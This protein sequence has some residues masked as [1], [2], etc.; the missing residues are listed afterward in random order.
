MDRMPLALALV[1]RARRCRKNKIKIIFYSVQVFHN[2]HNVSHFFYATSAHTP[3]CKCLDVK[4]SQCCIIYVLLQTQPPWGE[5]YV[6]PRALEGILQDMHSFM[7]LRVHEEQIFIS[8]HDGQAYCLAGWP[9]SFNVSFESYIYVRSS[10]SVHL[11]TT[12]YSWSP[13]LV[14]SSIIYLFTSALYH[15]YLLIV[16]VSLPVHNPGYIGECELTSFGVLNLI[17][18]DAYGAKL[19]LTGSCFFPM[20]GHRSCR[21]WNKHGRDVEWN[22]WWQYLN[23]NEN[24]VGFGEMLNVLYSRVVIWNHNLL[25]HVPRGCQVPTSWGSRKQDQGAAPLPVATLQSRQNLY[26]KHLKYHAP[27]YV[28]RRTVSSAALHCGIKTE[29]YSSFPIISSSLSFIIIRL[30]WNHKLCRPSR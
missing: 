2:L 25:P 23:A 13:P 28:Q 20:E 17:F 19:W 11:F 29:S 21:T 3:F 1:P 30:N 6:L 16:L 14:H 10:S 22:G 24:E 18:D 15:T 27:L 5:L 9:L 8:A 4:S 12:D 7:C 26:K